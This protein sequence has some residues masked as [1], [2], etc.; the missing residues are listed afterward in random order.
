MLSL[1]EVID[2]NDPWYNTKGHLHRERARI[3]ERF[4]VGETV[5]ET[6]AIQWKTVVLDRAFYECFE[7]TTPDV[8]ATFL[9]GIV[10]KALEL[11]GENAL[12]RAKHLV[13]ERAMALAIPEREW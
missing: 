13:R 3:I 1:A 12:H 11:S 5:L 6:R 7:Y 2:Q 4:G 9:A 8:F 10:A